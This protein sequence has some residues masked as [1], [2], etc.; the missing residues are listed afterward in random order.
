MTV[1]TV[2]SNNVYLATYCQGE[3]RE[4]EKRSGLLHR[5]LA[6]WT[7]L[8]ASLSERILGIQGDTLDTAGRKDD[9]VSLCVLRHNGAITEGMATRA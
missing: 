2:L 7:K 5:I 3:E 6:S 1:I 8:S 4:P 9:A